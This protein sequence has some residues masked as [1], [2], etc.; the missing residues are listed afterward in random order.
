M[1]HKEIAFNY[2]KYYASMDFERFNLF[3]LIKSVCKKQMTLFILD[4]PSISHPLL[5]F[6]M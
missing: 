4:L 6:P 3:K 2:N 1:T 5:F